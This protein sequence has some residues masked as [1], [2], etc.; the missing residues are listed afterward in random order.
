MKL[1][2]QEALQ[3]L[4]DY[5]VSFSIEDCVSDRVTK[6]A[7]TREDVGG[8]AIYHRCT[9]DHPMDRFQRAQSPFTDDQ[10]VEFTRV[11]PAPVTVQ[12][13]VEEP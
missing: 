8:E 12:A 9:Y 5:G 1:V 11:Y 10:E 2:G 4:L 7:I 13:F 6:T 3:Y